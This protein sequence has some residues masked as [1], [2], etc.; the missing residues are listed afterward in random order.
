[1][2]FNKKRKQIF[3]ITHIN[4]QLLE[5]NYCRLTGGVIIYAVQ[6][7]MTSFLLITINKN[8]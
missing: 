2:R 3:L 5:S 8:N 1:M 6:Y 7:N 4:P